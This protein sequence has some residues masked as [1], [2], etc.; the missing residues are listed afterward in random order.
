MKRLVYVVVFL[1]IP[2][3]A[4]HSCKDELDIKQDYDFEVTHLP[5]PKRLKVGETAEI[6][7]QINREGIYDET[8][9]YVRYFQTDGSGEVTDE[10]GEVFKPNDAYELTKDVFRLYF[11]S[12]SDDQHNLDFYFFDSFNTIKEVSFSFSNNTSDE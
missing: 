12:K 11:T 7:F 9:F 4:F 2:A 8:K 6:R 1:M 3:M 10:K 5:V